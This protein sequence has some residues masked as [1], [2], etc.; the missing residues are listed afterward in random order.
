YRSAEALADDLRRWLVGEP[1]TARPVSTLERLWKW[2]RRHPSLAGALSVIA[3][4]IVSIAIGSAIAAARLQRIAR[5]NADLA[6]QREG[7][8]DGAVKAQEQA[9][10]AGAEA[11]RQEQAER[12]ERYRAN[13]M[14]AVSA[15]E[16]NNTNIAQQALAAAPEEHRNWEWRYLEC[17]LDRSSRILPGHPPH[18]QLRDIPLTP[19]GKQVV[20]YDAKSCR[21]RLWDVV[22]EKEIAAL[23]HAA[24]VAVL[25]L[26]PDGRQIAVGSKDGSVRLWEPQTNRPPIEL[27]PHPNEVWLVLYSPDGR[28][29]LSRDPEYQWSD[30]I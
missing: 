30:A 13:I 9:E 26:R 4:L 28:T 17:Q 3:S 7:E 27:A 2:S 8:R 14:T 11:R 5:E 15:L 29:F 1:I 12:W 10:R 21:V 20:L 24:E 22:A 18:I 6:D 16:L 23:P 25:A 19:D